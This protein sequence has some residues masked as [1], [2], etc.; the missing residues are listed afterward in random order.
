MRLPWLKGAVVSLD[1]MGCQK[2]IAEQI[3]KAEADYLLALKDNH[4]QLREDVR[5]WL[6]TE[7]GQGRLLPAET[8][9]KDHGR[10]DI[11]RYALSNA[12]EWLPQKR[13]WAGLQAVGRVESSR[14]VGSTLTTECRY[15]RCSFTDQARFAEAVRSHWDIENGQHWVLDV[16]F[17]ED[18]N[19]TRWSHAP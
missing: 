5:L 3:V 18:A 15:Y 11:R 10:L 17:G 13:Q 7:V 19:R 12:S 2:T 9:E 1:A 16:Q 4:P 14:Q 6:D 8:V